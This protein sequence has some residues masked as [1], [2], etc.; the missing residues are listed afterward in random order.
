MKLI[1]YFLKTYPLSCLCV[2]CIW[3]L[4]LVPIP[5]TPLDDIQMIDKWTHFA[6]YGGLCT[7]LWVEYGLHHHRM[8]RG[9]VLCYGVLLPLLLGGMVE[10]VQATCTGGN[11]SGDILDFLADGV[12]VAL[13]TLIGIPVALR[14]SRR[15]KG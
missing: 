11:R 9:K 4:C 3:T 5:A 12:G 13:G 7:L 15:N 2:A 6:M 1:G 14:L 10:V 8:K